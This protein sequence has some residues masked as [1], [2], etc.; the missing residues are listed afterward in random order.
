MRLRFSIGCV[1]AVTGTMAAC[2]S[3][4]TP[5]LLGP[6][7][8]DQVQS[9]A[10]A[11]N[12]PS[13]VTY[14]NIGAGTND[15]DGLTTYVAPNGTIYYDTLAAPT[16]K[17]GFCQSASGNV[18]KF[19]PATKTF[20]EIAMNAEPI[21]L[22]QTSDGA[23]W[24]AENTS[25]QAAGSVGRLA[26]FSPFTPGGLTEVTLPYA[27]P[28]A[29]PQPRDL[30]IGVDGDVWFTDGFGSH[31][32]KIPVAGPFTTSSI[33]MYPV[34]NG[35]AGTPQVPAR[36]WGITAGPSGDLWFADFLNGVIYQVTTSGS[37]TA[38]I[39]PQ[40][41]ALG[42]SGSS[43]PS[44]IVPGSGKLYLTQLSSPGTLDSLTSGG[45]F[46]TIALPAG[47]APYFAASHTGE[48]AFDDLGGDD[49]I[50]IYTIATGKLVELPTQAA[51]LKSLLHVPNGLS[52]AHDGSI[53]F[54]CY[55]NVTV[56]SPLCLG[57]LTL[58][59]TW[60]VFPGTIFSLGVG[61]TK[62]QLRGIGEKG[63]SAPFTA[64]SS[65]TAIATV[66]AANVPND[67]HNFV[68]T[69]IAAGTVTITITDA[70]SRSVPI[71]VTV[72]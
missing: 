3:P 31:V 38:H 63:D 21:G 19:D 54:A 46:A 9:L 37:L 11:P 71:T 39:T 33:T 29:T 66:A 20:T 60:S 13:K 27:A 68:V 34:P 12:V 2:S 24:A 51:D 28:G 41:L 65:N 23:L 47:A 72:K 35:P 36:P 64:S 69:G 56:G 53:W 45:T 57:H 58:G 52:F 70:H 62:T 55:G 26:R 4:G 61:A 22:L 44:Y 43:H 59:S 10:L 6:T 14:Y 8:L 50:G 42:N 5:P 1:L 18:G 32:G 49:S 17:F 48:V 15:V 16:C 67:D 25:L 7:T 30:A 40:Q